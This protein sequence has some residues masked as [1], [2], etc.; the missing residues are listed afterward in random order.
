MN[1]LVFSIYIAKH[2]YGNTIPNNSS[3]I[4][5]KELH[6][7][8]PLLFCSSYCFSKKYFGL[9]AFLPLLGRLNLYLHVYAATYFGSDTN[10]HIKE[11]YC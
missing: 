7:N 2:L 8:T 3:T 11:N 6:F 1:L 4:F 5:F 10:G 9:F